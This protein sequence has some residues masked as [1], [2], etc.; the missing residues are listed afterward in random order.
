MQSD[1]K[2]GDFVARAGEDLTDKE[3]YLAYVTHDAG[4]PE[5]K[6]PSAISDLALFL[7]LDGAE[8]GENVAL[9]PLEP[10]MSVRGVLEG[11]CNPGDVLVLAAIAG[12][13]AGMVRAL[14]TAGG[15]YRG[16]GIA[17]EKGVDGQHILMQA[18]MIGNI[19]VT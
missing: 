15:T 7:I 19:T 17:M 11:T 9:R 13:D 2:R 5:V 4:V 8:D 14:P 3:G 1:V 10:G 12:E 6:L 18:S 16:L